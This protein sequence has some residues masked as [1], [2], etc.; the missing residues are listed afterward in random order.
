MGDAQGQGG[1]GRLVIFL[2]ENHCGNPHLHR[3]LQDASI[4]FERHTDHFP[5]GLPDAE[6]IPVVAARGWIVLTADARIRYNSLERDAVKAHGLRLFYF[7]RNDFSGA[8]MG[9]ILRAALSRII[10]V[11]ETEQPPFVASINRRGDVALRDL[12]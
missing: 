9:T 11:C 6:W 7:A 2:D 4:P 5:R 8:E 12:K 3:V 1:V 10:K